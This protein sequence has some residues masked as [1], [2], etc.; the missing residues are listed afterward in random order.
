MGCGCGLNG[1]KGQTKRD[2]ERQEAVAA[3]KKL[4]P[5]GSTVFYV[6]KHTSTTG[7]NRS[8]AFYVLVP[9][10]GQGQTAA[11]S[12]TSYMAKLWGT[13]IDNAHNGMKIQSDGHQAVAEL[14]H[15]LYGSSRNVSSYEL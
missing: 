2:H 11:R 8:I 12:I 9:S 3:L 7:Y 1:V 13:T 6:T 10:G 5:E 15:A 4:V 14:A